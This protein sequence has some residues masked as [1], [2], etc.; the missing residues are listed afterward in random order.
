MAACGRCGEVILRKKLGPKSLS[1][2]TRGGAQQDV[3]IELDPQP[4]PKGNVIVVGELCGYVK[5][6]GLVR[7]LNTPLYIRHGLTCINPLGLKLWRDLN[8]QP[9]EQ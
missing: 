6:W 3:W 5:D 1:P 8:W 9:E 4:S 7:H 2:D